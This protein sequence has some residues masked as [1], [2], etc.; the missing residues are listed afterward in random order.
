[1]DRPDH[2][3]AIHPHLPRIVDRVAVRIGVPRHVEPVPPPALAVVRRREQPV[4]HL[5]VRIRRFIL[6]ERADLLRRRRQ[7]R[8][9][10][11]HAAHPL[12]FRRRAA[13]PPPRPPPGGPGGRAPPPPPLPPPPVDRAAAPA[14]T[15][16]GPIRAAPPSAP[17]STRSPARST[18]APPRY[19]RRQAA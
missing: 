13:P 15:P 19:P 12:P 17:Q 18:P 2:P 5:L 3:I 9:I 6:D 16:S 10:Q 14:E 7:P 8:N 11:P 4:D 1:I